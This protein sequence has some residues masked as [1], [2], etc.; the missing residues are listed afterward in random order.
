MATNSYEIS[1]LRWK[2]LRVISE[3]IDIVLVMGASV[4]IKYFLNQSWV[5]TGIY[6]YVIGF[7]YLTCMTLFTKNTTLGMFTSRLKIIN[8]AEPKIMWRIARLFIHSLNYMPIVNFIMIPTNLTVLCVAP[9]KAS[10]DLAGRTALVYRYSH[11]ATYV[12]ER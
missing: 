8:L 10:Y 6:G 4:I 1:T 9:Q 5:M 3:L 12:P 11:M 2:V 7:V